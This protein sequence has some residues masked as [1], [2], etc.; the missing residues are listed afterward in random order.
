MTK[1]SHTPD[2]RSTCTARW[3]SNKDDRIRNLREPFRA[4]QNG[5]ECEYANEVGTFIE[6]GRSQVLAASFDGS[7][8]LPNLICARNCITSLVSAW[9]IFQPYSNVSS[10]ELAFMS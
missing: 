1:T 10:C 8:R 7:A 9:M 5:D 4:Y 6:Y 3:T 2:A